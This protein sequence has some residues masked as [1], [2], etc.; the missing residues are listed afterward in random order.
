MRK[1]PLLVS[2]IAVSMGLLSIA[3]TPAMA[4]TEHHTTYTHPG[5]QITNLLLNVMKSSA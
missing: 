4:A 2:S 3:A 1:V 5:V